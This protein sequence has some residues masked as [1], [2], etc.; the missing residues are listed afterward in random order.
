MELIKANEEK[1]RSTFLFKDRYRKFWYN[2]TPGWIQ[3]HVTILERVFPSYVLGYGINYIDF[4]ILNGINANTIE[5]TDDFCKKIYKFCLEN[6]KQTSPYFHGDW[7]LSNMIVNEDEIF[8][9]DW[10]NLGV[11]PLDD[12]YKKL[13]SD[14]MSA[15]GERF[16]RIKNDSASI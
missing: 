12:V 11:Y 1:K 14:L 7:V 8:L 5:H 9:C 3:D 10:D 4:K 15:F 2:A 13:E 6:I 16:E